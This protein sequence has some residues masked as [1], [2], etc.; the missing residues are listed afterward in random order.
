MVNFIP[1]ADPLSAVAGVQRA[2]VQKVPPPG[3]PAH[4]RGSQASKR[5]NQALHCRDLP[6][7]RDRIC[8]TGKTYN[9]GFERI[10]PGMSEEDDFEDDDEFDDEFEDDEGPEGEG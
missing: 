7:P 10:L 3:R 1:S 6:V 5:R 9:D 2:V 8:L 4:R